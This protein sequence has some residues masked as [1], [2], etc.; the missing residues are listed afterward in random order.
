MMSVSVD[1][2]QAGSVNW[3]FVSFQLLRRFQPTSN[4][5]GSIP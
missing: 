3:E 1:A 5:S 2:T 4:G